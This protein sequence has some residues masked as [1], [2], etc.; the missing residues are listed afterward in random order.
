[1]KTFIMLLAGGVLTFTAS[2]Q[3]Q[4]TTIAVPGSTKT[5]ANAISGN[6]IVGQYFDTQWHPFRY[7]GSIFTTLPEHPLAIPGQTVPLGVDA[8]NIV[9]LYSSGPQIHGYLYDG[10]TY[11]TL[12]AP[13]PGSDFTQAYGIY[14]N[15]IVG[16]YNDSNKITHSLLFDGTTYTS[17]PDPE[18]GIR[19]AVSTAIFE[20]DIVGYY[21]DSDN[22]DHAFLYKNNVYTVLDHPLGVNGTMAWGISGRYIV[23]N[24]DDDANVS[25]GFLYDG[26]T[27]TTIDHPLGIKGT[28]LYNLSGT[29]A[30]GG[31]YDGDDV[32]HSFVVAV[33]PVPEP[34]GL[35]LAVL[36]MGGA[37]TLRRRH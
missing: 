23:G 16:R 33:S 4:F 28:E 10:T 32:F 27:F 25:H 19:G 11:T 17:L 26:N 12:D 35:I 36:G 9:G 29:N 1:M 13:F 6:I 37:F 14:G 31:Y 7:N 24:Y 30:V 34:S 5:Y 15:L 8:N 20:N 3:L 18:S 22:H 21:S 2:A